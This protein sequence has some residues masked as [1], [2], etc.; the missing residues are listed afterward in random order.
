MR[1]FLRGLFRKQDRMHLKNFS[2]FKL[3]IEGLNLLGC[4]FSLSLEVMK[5]KKDEVGHLKKG[6]TMRLLKITVLR[7]CFVVWKLLALGSHSSM[8]QSTF[9][10]YMYSFG[11]APSD[12]KTWK[13]NACKSLRVHAT[14][15][16]T[17]LFFKLRFL[18]ANK[19]LLYQV[20]N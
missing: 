3:M 19:N 8:R 18:T 12:G 17:C 10:T 5:R 14:F 6:T 4:H 7:L 1:I 13:V 9:A 2:S 11:E 16:P 20:I 15:F